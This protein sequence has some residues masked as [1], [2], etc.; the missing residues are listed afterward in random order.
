MNLEIATLL[1]LLR[2]S[3]GISGSIELSCT[4]NWAKVMNLSIMHGVHGVAF[5]AF[6][7]LPAECR[8]SKD[9]FIQ[10]AAHCLLLEDNYNRQWNVAN[11]L[12]G[13]FE[14]KGIELT[15]LK[16]FS[17]AQYYA[18]PKHR[19]SCDLDLFIESGWDEACRMLEDKGIELE[20]EV[21]KEVEFYID[22]VYVECHRCIT[23]FRGHRILQ[24]FELYIRELLHTDKKYFDN[25][26]L[27]CP[28]IM[29]SVMLFMEH[30][31]GDFLHGKLMLKHVVDWIVLR[32]QNLDW[33]EVEKKMME[34]KFERFYILINS[35][36]DVVEGK[37]KIESIPSSAQQIFMEIFSIKTK[38]NMEHSWFK[39]RMSVFFDIINNNKRF[40]KYGYCSM[41]SFLF[42]SLYTHF[43]KKEVK[44]NYN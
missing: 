23:P 29:F 15:I 28:P 25:S 3:L 31:L 14:R 26:R 22:N 36:A 16:G 34:F 19:Y 38:A 10:W 20:R 7:K 13:F 33:D 18:N 32:K 30:A 9:V 21:Y 43:F 11:K 44:L 5:D 42:N 1:Q 27:I 17:F 6:E 41:Y 39:K 4:I 24:K 12:V 37:L 8:P 40:R 35:L 2:V